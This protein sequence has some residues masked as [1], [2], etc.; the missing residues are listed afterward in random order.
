MKILLIYILDIALSVII[1]ISMSNFLH[2]KMNCFF[3]HQN[4]LLTLKICSV[5]H[6]I[7]VI[8]LGYQSIT[9]SHWVPHNSSLVP[10]ETKLS[11]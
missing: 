8:K 3:N 9:R 4:M 5:S 10:D 6:V 11:K 7:I 2:L 1:I